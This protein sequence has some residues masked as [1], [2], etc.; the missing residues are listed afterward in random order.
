MERFWLKWLVLTAMMA[1]SSVTATWQAHI[2]ESWSMQ[3]VTT[4]PDDIWSKARR[5]DWDPTRENEVMFRG[6]WMTTKV[7]NI[8]NETNQ[9]VLISKIAWWA[10]VS[11]KLMRDRRTW[12]VYGFWVVEKNWKNVILDTVELWHVTLA[13]IQELPENPG[14]KNI[15]YKI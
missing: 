10:T 12:E 7:N 13:F 11:I 3:K 4:I 1:C 9:Y 8:D 5:I 2:A 14:E 6:Q 15:P